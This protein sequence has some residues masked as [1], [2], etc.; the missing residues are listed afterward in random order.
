MK[1]EYP[2]VILFG[3]IY[4][5]WRERYVIP[6]LDKLGVTYYHPIPPSGKWYRELGN[7][8]AEVM[9]HCETIVMH[10]TPDLPSFAGL[11]E[12]GWGALSATQ[13]K[14]NFILSIPQEEYHQPMPWWVRFIPP[15]K[16]MNKTIEDYANRSRFLVD[17]HAR[18]LAP[19]NAH[20][21]IVHDIHAVVAELRKLYS[22][23]K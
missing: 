16:N 4:G 10:F 7:R 5:E 14:Q 9:E 2:Q 22:S 20:L 6:V 17:A 21:I 19:G 1:S 13:R 3:S 11:A 15:L 18:R 23:P 8:E 12:T